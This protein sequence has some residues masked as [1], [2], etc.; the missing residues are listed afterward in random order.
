[1]RHLRSRQELVK[2]H[3]S[4]IIILAPSGWP[5]GRGLQRKVKVG[6]SEASWIQSD[7]SMIRHSQRRIWAVETRSVTKAV[8]SRF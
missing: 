5:A 8:L 3:E 1:M 7:P 2:T 6:Y 4:D